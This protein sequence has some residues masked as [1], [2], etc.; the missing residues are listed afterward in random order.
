MFENKLVCRD[1]DYYVDVLSTEVVELGTKKYPYKDLNSVFIELVNLH[2]N[3]DRTINV[4]VKERTINYLETK[5]NHV[6][7]TNYVLFTTYSSSNSS[8]EKSTLIGTDDATKINLFAVPTMFNILSN[9]TLLLEDKLTESGEYTSS[10][11]SLITSSLS[12]FTITSS[13]VKVDNFELLTEHS[14]TLI[15]EYRFFRTLKSKSTKLSIYN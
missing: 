14:S 12:V 8:S 4:Y 5:K 11:I 15:Y 6:V 3:S 1:F 13:N 9:T 7:N 2:S 10:E